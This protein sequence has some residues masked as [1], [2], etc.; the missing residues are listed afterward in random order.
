MS[1]MWNYGVRRP[2]RGTESAPALV[3]SGLALVSWSGGPLGEL[4]ARTWIRLRGTSAWL[5]ANRN[6]CAWMERTPHYRLPRI[7]LRLMLRTRKG[8]MPRA[9]QTRMKYL[10]QFP[11]PRITSPSI[12]EYSVKLDLLHRN[13][14]GRVRHGGAFPE[15]IA[16]AWPLQHATLP[17]IIKSWILAGA[18]G[19][20]RRGI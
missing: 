12:F 2:P 20:R 13:E 4:K 14:A 17:T 18:T 3:C 11:R 16:V 10:V 19:E 5:W 9:R 15:A 1:S 8:R 7:I 6:Y